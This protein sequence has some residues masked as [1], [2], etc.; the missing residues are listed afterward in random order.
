MRLTRLLKQYNRI[1]RKATFT[2]YVCPKDEELHTFYLLHRRAVDKFLNQMTNSLVRPISFV[3]TIFYNYT[4]TRNLCAL[5]GQ[6]K[7]KMIRQKSILCKNKSW[8]SLGWSYMYSVLVVT[9]DSFSAALTWTWHFWQIW[10]QFPF[11]TCVSNLHFTH[12]LVEAAEKVRIH[13]LNVNYAN[14]ILFST[15]QQCLQ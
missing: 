9:L 8:Q 14:Q 2:L 11:L 15:L 10:N 3:H 6:L 5:I 7:L 4:S 1:D 12:F 13:A